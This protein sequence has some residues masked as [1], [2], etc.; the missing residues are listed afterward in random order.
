MGP[1]EER[2][3]A[4]GNWRLLI[5]LSRRACL[6][7]GRGRFRGWLLFT[8]V[9]IDNRGGDQFPDLER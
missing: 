8:T 4:I 1:S 5:V 3:T 9:V 7:D 6:S 2:N